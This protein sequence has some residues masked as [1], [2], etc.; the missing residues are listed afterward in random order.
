MMLSSI[1]QGALGVELTGMFCSSANLRRSARPL[2][3]KQLEYEV[4]KIKGGSLESIKER[5]DAPGGHNL[6]LGVTSFPSQLDA[7]HVVSLPGA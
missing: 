7:H 5:R 1:D 2:R 4:V 6:H 3:N